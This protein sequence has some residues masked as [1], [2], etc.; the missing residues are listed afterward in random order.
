MAVPCYVS[1]KGMYAT[2]K[3][4]QFKVAVIEILE[5]SGMGY[6]RAIAI[7]SSHFPRWCRDASPGRSFGCV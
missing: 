2:A 7:I 4:R 5:A 6:A 3:T 1:G